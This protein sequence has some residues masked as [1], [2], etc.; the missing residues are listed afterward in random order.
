M[1]RSPDQRFCFRYMDSTIPR[2]FKSE[3][4]SFYP[5]SVAAQ[6]GL[7]QT[8]SETPKTGFLAVTAQMTEGLSRLHLVTNRTRYRSRHGLGFL[9]NNKV[10]VH[11]K[12]QRNDLKHIIFIYNHR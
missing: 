7:C 10:P 6:A 5:S 11:G 3:I 12:C 9:R 2:L 1:K 4:S 8:W